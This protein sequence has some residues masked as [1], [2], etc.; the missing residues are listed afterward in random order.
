MELTRKFL[1]AWEEIEHEGETVAFYCAPLTSAQRLNV[2]ALQD[3][4][5]R[6]GD[7]AMM[8]VEGS[9]Q[10]WRG[11]TREGA[12]VPYSVAALREFF[13]DGE[14]VPVLMELSARVGKR[15]R[16]TGEEQKNS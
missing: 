7:A 10:D 1:P 15:A 3:L 12:P 9:V 5:G 13:A 4:P 6:I 2:F 14:R 11:I 16:L 8:C